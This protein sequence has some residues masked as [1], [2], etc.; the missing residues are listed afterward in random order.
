MSSRALLSFHTL[1]GCDT[2]STFHEKG[3]TTAWNVWQSFPDVTDAFLH[4][5][6]FPKEVYDTVMEYIENFVQGTPYIYTHFGLLTKQAT[7]GA[8][9]LLAAIHSQTHQIGDRQ[10][11][12]I[13]GNLFG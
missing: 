11:T 1:P 9:L 6:T 7:Y 5:S 3:K 10:K 8:K 2:T 12:I 4:L 13:T